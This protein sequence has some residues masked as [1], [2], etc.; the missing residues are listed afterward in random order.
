MNKRINKLAGELGLNPEEQNIPVIKTDDIKDRVNKALGI[1]QKNKFKRPVFK[2]A[3]ILATA[4]ALVLIVGLFNITAV[5]ALFKNLFVPEFIVSTGDE[6]LVSAVFNEP[7]LVATDDAGEFWLQFANK[8]RRE[9]G[10]CEI[11]LFFTAN[12][13]LEPSEIVPFTATAI[14]NTEKYELESIAL[15]GHNNIDSSFTMAN[16]DFPDV[17][18]FDLQFKNTTTHI[19]MSEV[20]N[21]EKEAHLSD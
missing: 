8:V 15:G 14:I 18:E 5:I 7:V 2:P 6:S 9:D 17:N 10:R 1:T 21:A 16:Y 11:L 13:T 19:I 20:G 4:A 3:K 12:R